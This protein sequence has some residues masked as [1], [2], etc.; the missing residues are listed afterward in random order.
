ME[1]QTDKLI[2][3]RNKDWEREYLQ[4]KLLGEVITIYKLREMLDVDDLFTTIVDFIL[5]QF[6]MGEKDNEEKAT[7]EWWA[8][9]FALEERIKD[10][11]IDEFYQV[12]TH[13]LEVNK[14]E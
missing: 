6:P 4:K 9:S 10:L 8:A 5:D 14:K 7:D 11:S 2:R 13:R 12:A 3:N 1:K